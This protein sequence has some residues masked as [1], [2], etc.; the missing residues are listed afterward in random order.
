MKSGPE[1]DAVGDSLR[2]VASS[3]VV[4]FTI[5]VAGA[6]L[7]YFSQML[8]AR[9]IGVDSYGAYAY[10]LAWATVLAYFCALGFDVALLRY[11]PAY[12][13]T[14]SWSL[15]RGVTRYA[16]M[17][18]VAASI[19][20]GICGI[21]V[22]HF[23]S[24]SLSPELSQTFLIG[25]LLVP[26][27]AL[28]WLR[29]SMLR[30]YGVFLTAVS[31]DRILR[32]AILIALIVIV[33]AIAHVKIGAQAVMIMTLVGSL[34]GLAWAIIAER[35]VRPS[36]V[37]AAAHHYDFSQWNR[38][39][40]PLVIIAAIDILMNR[41]GLIWLG[42][43]GN[44]RHAGIYGLAFSIAFI[45]A[46]PRTAV[47]TL[48][49]PTFSGH[50]AR[51]EQDVLQQLVTR[52]TLWTFFAASGIALFLWVLAS[53]LLRMFGPD[54]AEGLVALR[55][56]LVGQVIASAAGS[57]L[58]V[59]TMSHNERGAAGIFLVSAVFNFATTALFA[60]WFGLV[61]AAIAGALTLV[62]SN[63]A[64]MIFIKLRLNL[65]SGI[66]GLLVQPSEPIRQAPAE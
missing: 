4:S 17:C 42:W 26:V 37:G 45:V 16:G 46:L 35:D 38:T 44:I 50:F 56:L 18:A 20:V 48:F 65:L 30:G 66:L 25:F 57:P 55:I 39:A 33:V 21:T 22:L 7:A 32:E 14:G 63:A 24:S 3:S 13:M 62:V 5:L 61:G 59:M 58:Y 11:I 1:A 31:A 41:M 9:M 29:C 47:N 36:E 52:T 28:L 43:Q 54:F 40:A 19:A 60:T 15:L 8:I 53:P 12:R 10:V 2:R 49:A 23:Q 34:C 6:F 51:G 64:L 27:L